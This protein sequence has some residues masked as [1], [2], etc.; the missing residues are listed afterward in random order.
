MVKPYCQRYHM[1]WRHGKIKLELEWPCFPC[2]LVLTVPGGWART[3]INNLTRLRTFMLHVNWLIEQDVPIGT[4]VASLSRFFF[5]SFSLFHNRFDW[6]RSRG[7]TH[8]NSYHR[9][10]KRA[11]YC[12]HIPKLWRVKLCLYMWMKSYYVLFF[13][14][15]I[16]M[17]SSLELGKFP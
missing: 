12:V 6:L 9:Y 16:P 5:F 14:E 15:L 4:T 8:S 13:F 17:V 7:Y 3:V 11:I 2:W 10:P 1:L